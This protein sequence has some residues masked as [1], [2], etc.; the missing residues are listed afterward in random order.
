LP[1][2]TSALIGLAAAHFSHPTGLDRLLPPSGRTDAS[3]CLRSGSP[4]I[5]AWPDQ[6]GPIDAMDKT[7]DPRL[8][9]QAAAAA[10]GYMFGGPW[11]TLAGT[12]PRFL[13]KSVLPVMPAGGI[14]PYQ[15]IG[16]IPTA[17]VQALADE[18]PSM[19]SEKSNQ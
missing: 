7:I 18:I 10:G 16:R 2:I 3:W 13:P 9:M 8:T 5:T 1:Q 19:E 4:H 11:G 14:P 17:L 15:G 12:L 6:D